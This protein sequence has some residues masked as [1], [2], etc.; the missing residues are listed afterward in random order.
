VTEDDG[1][2]GNLPRSRP[3]RRSERRAGSRRT[4]GAT[5]SRSK[6]SGGRAKTKD[7][8][9]RAET[10]SR[11]GARSDAAGGARRQRS[12]RREPERRDRPIEPAERGDDIL[13][14]AARAAGETTIAG[15]RFASRLAGGALRR[16]PRP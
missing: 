11:A 1:I 13:T 15:I 14:V 4:A 5:A 7:S 16:L 8:A 2:L 12:P 6:A 9:T 3:G 10:G